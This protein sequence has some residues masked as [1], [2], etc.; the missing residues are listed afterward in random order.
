MVKGVAE[1]PQK[2]WKILSL[3]E[4]GTLSPDLA[5]V[6]GEHVP[7]GKS[8][9]SNIGAARQRLSTIAGELRRIGQRDLASRVNDVVSNLMY[10]RS[11]ARRMPIHSNP[12]TPQ[13]I[14]EVRRLADT[15]D[16]HSSEIAAE[17]GVN[18]GRVSE[19]LQGDR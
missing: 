3:L 14:R 9:M 11:P 10:R 6:R 13:I 7:T 5:I 16:M 4:N 19:I 17:L 8:S 12:V 2:T 18:P 1:K 15:T